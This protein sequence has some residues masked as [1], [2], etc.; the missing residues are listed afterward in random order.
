M[1]PTGHDIV[2]MALTM[3][4]KQ[5]IYGYE[6]EPLSTKK[7]RAADCSELVEWV[8]FQCG[9][10]P[11]MPD[12][13]VWQLRHCANHE[14]EIELEDAIV[15]EG[16]LLFFFSADPLLVRPKQAHVAISQGSESRLTIE[17]R[18]RRYGIG[19]WQADAR[20]WTHAALIPGVHYPGWGTL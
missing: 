16:A 14:S 6:I 2:Q 8:C 19:E 12:G 4:G 7:P 15:T 20:G 9:V 5:Y 1:N 13:A 11:Y 10:R 3:R 17:A 18:G